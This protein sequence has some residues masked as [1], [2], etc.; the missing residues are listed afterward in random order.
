MWTQSGRLIPQTVL[1]RYLQTVSEECHE[2]VSLHAPLQPMMDRS[3]SE[4]A[5]QR[6]ECRFDIRQLDI[7]DP[8]HRRIFRRQIRPQQVMTIALF[9]LSQFDFFDAKVK[10]SPRDR[11]GGG[12]KSN[13]HESKRAARFFLRRPDPQQQL[14]ATRQTTPHGAQLAQQPN[15]ALTTYGDL[16]GLASI[17]ARQHVELFLML[18]QLYLHGISDLLPGQSQ[19]LLFVL[20]DAAFRRPHQIRDLPLAHFFQSRFSGD[21]AVHHPHTPRLPV[22]FFDPVQKRLQRFLLRSVAVHHFVGQRKSVRRH[23]QSNHHLHAI[24]PAVAAVAALRLV[25]LFHSAFEIRARQIVKQYFEIGGKQL[26]PLL[27]QMNE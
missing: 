6:P 17:A 13:G 4:I 7:A 16:F 19:P 3:Q 26:G 21:A 22:S 20:I 12:R 14:I 27:L 11:F 23:D 24:G 9:G 25:A 15:Q 8:Q 18:I 10:R 1:Q 2:D 5:L